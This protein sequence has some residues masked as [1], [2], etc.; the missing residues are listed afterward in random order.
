MLH[1]ALRRVEHAVIITAELERAAD[2][3]PSYTVET[4]QALHQKH[5]HLHMRLLIGADQL[6]QFDRWRDPQRIIALAEPLVMVR[7]PATR[8]SLLAALPPAY[9]R[10]TWQQRLVDVPLVDASSSAVRRRIAAG[11][12]AQGMI[13]PVVETYIREHHLYSN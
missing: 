13:D 9:D 1:L 10:Q 12:D 6:A 4:L 5:P 2:G 11:E 7:P 8:E 3:R